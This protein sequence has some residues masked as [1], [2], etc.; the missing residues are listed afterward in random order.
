MSCNSVMIFN[1]ASAACQGFIQGA[2]LPMHHATH[3]PVINKVQ[4]PA[5]KLNR[6]GLIGN[7][8]S[9]YSVE[10]KFVNRILLTISI[11]TSK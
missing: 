11:S 3:K 1:S 10:Y 8:A 2:P 6:V 5:M 4:M 7:I 9:D